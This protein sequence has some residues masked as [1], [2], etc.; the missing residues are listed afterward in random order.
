M[1]GSR[2]VLMGEPTHLICFSYPIYG[3]VL[4]DIS[5]FGLRNDTQDYQQLTGRRQPDLSVSL[6]MLHT[7]HAK[8]HI[9]S[10]HRCILHLTPCAALSA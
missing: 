8:N 5:F 1:L 2:G 6:G 9:K 7:R 3:G 10:N 4:L